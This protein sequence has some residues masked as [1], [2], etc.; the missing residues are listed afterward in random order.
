[1]RSQFGPLLVRTGH[2]MRPTP[3]ALQ[4]AFNP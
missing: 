3:R 4:L 2:G 1:M